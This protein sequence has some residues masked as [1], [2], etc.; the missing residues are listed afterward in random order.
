MAVV[1]CCRGGES[2][3]V[4]L[5]MSSRAGLWRRHGCELGDGGEMAEVGCS[6]GFVGHVQEAM[7][8]G[9]G[10]VCGFGCG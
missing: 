8:Q 7:L 9:S 2:Q 3:P 1:L 6:S 4:E 10:E 5:S